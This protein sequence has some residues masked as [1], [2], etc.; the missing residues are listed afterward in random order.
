MA[1]FLKS[2]SSKHNFFDLRFTHVNILWDN[3]TIGHSMTFVTNIYV[4][5][6]RGYYSEVMSL[7]RYIVNWYIF[8][9]YLHFQSC[10]SVYDRIIDL[11]IATPQIILNYAAFLEDKNYF[12]EAFKV[13][14]FPIIVYT[15][16]IDY[17]ICHISL[18]YYL[19]LMFARLWFSF[20]PEY[21]IKICIIWIFKV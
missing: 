11:G 1:C 13:W 12:E 10:K 8:Q 5:C 17:N 6:L 2:N 7:L 14:T 16:V 3:L 21:C 19:S 20:L 18:G 9:Y 4:A 15:V